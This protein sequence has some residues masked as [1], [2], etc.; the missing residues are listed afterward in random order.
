MSTQIVQI[1]D[2]HLFADQ[3]QVLLGVP[4]RA[5]LQLVVDDVKQ[6][7]A[8]ADACMLTGDLSQDGSD[9]SYRS[10]REII[11]P[12]TMPKYVLPGNHDDPALMHTELE[13]NGIS[14]AGEF[15]CDGWLVI[16]LNSVATD[17][18]HGHL[19]NAELQRLDSTLQQYRERSCLIG[20]HHPVVPLGSAWID[21]LRL[22]NS[23]A[24]FAVINRHPQ[25]RIVTWGHAHQEY[26][27]RHK[28]VTLL[29]SPSTCV[30]FLPGE[31]NFATDSVHPGYRI[32]NLQDN[33]DFE[34]QLHRIEEFPFAVDPTKNGYR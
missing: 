33:G 34:T 9:L 7:F 13:R 19:S 15:M 2:T 1:S 29:G 31:K 16:M 14:A 21:G 10:L 26:T 22:R 20:L 5:S 6:R 24:L 30:Q 27:G 12:L 4:T 18:H 11:A 32:F 28:D 25:V 23:D 3:E 17:G 8:G